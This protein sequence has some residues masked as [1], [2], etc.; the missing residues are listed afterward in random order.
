MTCLALA[1]VLAAAALMFPLAVAALLGAWSPEGSPK[2][3]P[4]PQALPALPRLPGSLHR[5][6]RTPIISRLLM[7]RPDAVERPRVR[8]IGVAFGRE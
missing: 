4:L 6:L 7:C 2:S 5:L 3:S 8:P 1:L